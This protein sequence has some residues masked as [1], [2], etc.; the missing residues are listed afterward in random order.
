MVVSKEDEQ[1]RAKLLIHEIEYLGLK[2]NYLND[3][4]L[5]PMASHVDICVFYRHISLTCRLNRHIMKIDVTTPYNALPN[6]PPRH[7]LET[8]NILKH[9]IEA[10]AALAEKKHYAIGQ[11]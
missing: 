7:D 10:R 5:H 2:S 6:L 4:K 9:C 8:K 1:K 11:R 3:C